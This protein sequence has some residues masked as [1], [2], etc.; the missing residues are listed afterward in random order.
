MPAGQRPTVSALAERLQIRHHS[1]VELLDRLVHSGLV[2]RT[3][4][5]SDHR[6][7]LLSLTPKGESTVHRLALVHRAELESVGPALVRAL[8]ALLAADQSSAPAQPHASSSLVRR[9]HGRSRS[10]PPPERAPP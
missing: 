3:S 2:V 9:S 5:P 7:V 1:A 10:G 4:D 6:L 8:Q